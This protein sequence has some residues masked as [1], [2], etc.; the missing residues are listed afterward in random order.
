MRKTF[1]IFCVVDW[2]GRRNNKGGTSVFLNL[3]PFLI[4]HEPKGIL[5]IIL[6]LTLLLKCGNA[7][8]IDDE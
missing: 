4:C 7:V 8:M 5:V 2:V 6:L 3:I 1:F